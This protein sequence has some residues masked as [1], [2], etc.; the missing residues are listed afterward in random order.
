MKGVGT[1]LQLALPGQEIMYSA[2]PRHTA[3][4]MSEADDSEL[5]SWS[6]EWHLPN[7]APCT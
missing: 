7:S 2:Q 1:L 6:L 4:L 3:E 5:Q